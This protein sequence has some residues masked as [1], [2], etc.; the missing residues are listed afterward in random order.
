M[1][2]EKIVFLTLTALVL[3]VGARAQQKS[4]DVT[5]KVNETKT[6]TL[7]SGYSNT[8]QYFAGG[9]S[10]RWYS[11]NTSVASVSYTGFKTCTVTGKTEGTCR[12]YFYAS[13]NVDGHYD[14]YNFYWDVTVSGYTG[15]GGGSTP[16]EPQSATV[17][18]E[19][20]TME[21]GETYSLSY[22]V[23]PVNA[24]YTKEWLT[25]EKTIV[26]VDN[27][28]TVTALSP[29][30]ARAFI[31]IYGPNN[32]VADACVVNVVPASRTL[33]EEATEAPMAV[34]CA[35]VTVKRT[36]AADK[37]S[38]ICLPFAMS[39][40]QTKAA[41]GDGVEIADFAGYEAERDAEDRVVGLTVNFND[42]TEMEA[43]R[44]Y[45]IKVEED[46]SEFTADEVNIQPTLTPTA[47]FDN[48]LSGEEQVI[49]GSFIGTYTAETIIPEKALF[50]SDNKFWYSNGSKK[51]KA[52]RGYFDL[53]DVMSE[54]ESQEQLSRISMSVSTE[55]TG[56]AEIRKHTVT[57]GNYY[58]L[59][60]RRINGQMKKGLFIKN[61]RI[62]KR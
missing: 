59:Q 46:V 6:I 18:P 53:S 39:E 32:I 9:V 30:T 27:Q 16:V 2:R 33:D 22:S 60:G 31:W 8:L 29:G 37:W 42:V 14:T 4:G 43:N 19:E 55:D 15:G 38:T 28:G 50:I 24:Q 57:D 40:A 7:G 62:V 13:F 47:V 17:Y 58:D 54:V 44:P 3:C 1:K 21:V 48:G 35:N 12:V 20:I 11:S 34:S 23:S 49:Y 26:S 36:L 56:I 61:G 52:Y 51:I 5:V 41:F 25:Y 10:Y 45:I